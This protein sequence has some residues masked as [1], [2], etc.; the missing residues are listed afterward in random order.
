MSKRFMNFTGTQGV[1]WND[2]DWSQSEV[3]EACKIPQN[4]WSVFLLGEGKAYVC[5]CVCCTC[6]YNNV[7]YSGDSRSVLG[8]DTLLGNMLL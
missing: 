6:I 7:F 2:R 4:I 3:C 8:G 1:W 5:V